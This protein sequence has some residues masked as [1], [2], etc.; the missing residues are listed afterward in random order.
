MSFVIHPRQSSHHIAPVITTKIDPSLIKHLFGLDENRLKQ[1]ISHL[2]LTQSEKRVNLLGDL[3]YEIA[4]SDY[5]NNEK[6][7]IVNLIVSVDPYKVV[8]E[9]MLTLTS[10]RFVRIFNYIDCIEFKQDFFSFIY[11]RKGDF[12]LTWLAKAAFIIAENDSSLDVKIFL[13]NFLEGFS[14]A[15]LPAFV[16]FCFTS[17][18]LQDKLYILMAL[19]KDEDT[20]ALFVRKFYFYNKGKDLQKNCQALIKRIIAVHEGKNDECPV[21]VRC[22]V[23]Y[24][25]PDVSISKTILAFL[26]EYSDYGQVCLLKSCNESQLK[27]VLDLHPLPALH[28]K[29]LE[30]MLFMDNYFESRV[31]T[32][33]VFVQHIDFKQ[34]PKL[35]EALAN[36]HDRAQPPS[37]LALPY[38]A[39]E[40]CTD[41]A[42]EGEKLESQDRKRLF[43]RAIPSD[44]NEFRFICSLISKEQ[45]ANLFDNIRVFLDRIDE[46][47]DDY[48]FFIIGHNIQ[49]VYLEVK[50]EE[51]HEVLIRGDLVHVPPFYLALAVE[52]E[53]YRK[54][55]VK[56]SVYLTDEQLKA[57][58]MMLPRESLF[59][60][61]EIMF[62]RLTNDQYELA[63]DALPFEN[64][65]LYFNSKTDEFLDL[66]GEIQI[67]VQ[68]L[69]E[70]IKRLDQ[71]K[72]DKLEFVKAKEVF[73]RKLF[74]FQGLLTGA[75]SLRHHIIRNRILKITQQKIPM[76]SKT[77][78]TFLRFPGL[79]GSFKTIQQS[80]SGPE[81][82]YTLLAKLP[83][84]EAEDTDP[85]SHTAISDRFWELITSGSLVNLGLEHAGEIM[86]KGIVAD[87]DFKCLGLSFVK[88]MKI[89]ILRRRLEAFMRTV[90][91]EHFKFLR[92]T[93]KAENEKETSEFEKKNLVDYLELLKLSLSLHEDRFKSRLAAFQ[94]LIQNSTLNPAVMIE[95][96][97][98]LG[99]IAKVE[100]KVELEESLLGQFQKRLGD[101][102][103]PQKV[104]SI[105]SEIFVFAL[106]IFK[107]HDF[108]EGL[109]RYLQQEDLHLI[110][111]TMRET[112]VR[113]LTEFV[114]LG[115]IQQLPEDC[116][117]LSYQ[118]LKNQ[119]NKKE[120]NPS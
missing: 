21:A 83:A 72:N 86:Q 81:G 14:P 45:R 84:I 27:Y 99:E 104:Q 30:A 92:S 60:S 110:C 95:F 78:D 34:L 65:M 69:K 77:R 55:I 68:E 25:D 79:L 35:I 111:I 62:P 32:L 31:E 74:E 96:M 11:Q 53:E 47:P 4:D 3:L 98:I 89:I 50:D 46:D 94:D 56:A 102:P 88:Q 75:L 13:N 41:R 43:S 115:I 119:P 58:I 15:L 16:D 5:D 36:N 57:V 44:L 100:N 37:S 76:D 82:L 2:Y 85:L 18:K 93:K 67:Q 33:E 112:G 1:E 103:H 118:L 17:V 108:L 7:R 80:L 38:L 10:D 51:S 24:E 12:A 97:G 52:D 28:A 70:Q 19:I 117:R 105:C 116:Y 91:E 20:A 87:N 66:M 23:T 8:L 109:K 40:L 54:W 120:E 101:S 49:K 42:A 90:L 113:S 71:I 63:V 22:L 73:E 107:N 106:T 39:L 9:K 48:P 64:R 26:M 29:W 61:I 59:K 114:E 6:Q